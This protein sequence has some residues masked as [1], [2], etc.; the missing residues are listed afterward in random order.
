MHLEECQPDG[1]LFDQG[2]SLAAT[3][4]AHRSA[5]TKHRAGLGASLF[6][7][8]YSAPNT[9]SVR[10]RHSIT[11]EQSCPYKVR[12]TGGLEVWRFGTLA[13]PI[14]SLIPRTGLPLS[15]LIP[16]PKHEQQNECRRA[17][18]RGGIAR[19]SPCLCRQIGGDVCQR[20]E[21]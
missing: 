8:A 19:C 21:Q 14:R 16:W 3:R 12:R 11:L 13:L 20:E 10:I 17:S 4:P 15:P 7:V 2:D 18:S 6:E 1:G 5:L 9:V